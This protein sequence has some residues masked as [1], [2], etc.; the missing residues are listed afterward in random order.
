MNRA[1]NTAGFVYDGLGRCLKRTIN[2][3]VLLIAYDDWKA[4]EEFDPSG[5]VV[6]ANI[7]GGGADMILWIAAIQWDWR[8]RY[9]ITL[10]VPCSW[11]GRRSKEPHL[12]RNRSGIQF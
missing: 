9:S 7:C 1:A 11:L 6:G 2:G 12:G 10:R 5:N 3:N 4:I 8:A